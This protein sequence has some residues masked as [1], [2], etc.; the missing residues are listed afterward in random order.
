MA[1]IEHWKGFSELQQN[2]KLLGTEMRDRGTKLM[3]ARAAVPMRD[4]ARRRA[5]RL[6]VPD[7]RRLPGTLARAIQIWR[8]RVTPYAATY[9]VGVR[10]LSRAAVRKFKSHTDRSGKA[11]S[12]GDNP[13][14]PFYWRWVELGR[15]GQAPH[16]F[17]RPAFEAQKR[18][19]VRVALETG[20]N[21]VR[22]TAA[23]FK[24]RLR[25]PI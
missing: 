4:D 18:E 24:R 21:F 19:S 15:S 23:R 12:A 14:D 6:K 1:E 20:R 2:L 17:L 22:R 3:M 16:P 25:M 7:P 5:P 9:Y 10:G 11:L 8:K 13:N